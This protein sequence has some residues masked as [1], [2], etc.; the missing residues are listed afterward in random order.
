MSIIVR[1]CGR[2]DVLRETM[3]SLRLQTY[4]NIEIVVVE[5]GPD[6]SGEMLKTEFS[7]LNVLYKATGEKVGRSKAGNMAMEMQKCTFAL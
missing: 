2:P 7:D 4:T 6:V 3:Q 1:T 5:D